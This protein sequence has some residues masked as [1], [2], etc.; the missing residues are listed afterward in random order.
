MPIRTSLSD[1]RTLLGNCEADIL[2]AMVLA[3]E[4]VD[5]LLLAK[6]LSDTKLKHIEMYL[7]AHLYNQGTPEVVRESYGG[8]TFEYN[9][10]Q[11]GGMSGSQW[12]KMATMLDTSGTLER[13]GKQRVFINVV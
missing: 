2:P 6:G 13:L 4:M 3:S 9:R 7:A 11:G 5:D 8:A 12:G 10:G 1:V